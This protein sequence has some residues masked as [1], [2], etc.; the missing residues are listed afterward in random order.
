MCNSIG[1]K[2]S[3]VGWRGSS[4]LYHGLDAWEFLEQLNDFDKVEDFKAELE[5]LRLELCY[6]IGHKASWV[7][8]RV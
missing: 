5:G 1:H 7:G 6:S 2:A 8:W 4:Q 3:W